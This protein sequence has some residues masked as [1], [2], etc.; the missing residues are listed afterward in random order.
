MPRF[1]PRRTCPRRA[2]RA[3]RRATPQRPARE[4]VGTG[5]GWRHR[6]RRRAG[7]TGR[8]T[9]TRAPRAGHGA[10][11][12]AP[13]PLASP[14]RLAG[15]RLPRASRDRA[16]RLLFERFAA[17]REPW[18]APRSWSA[19]CPWRGSSPR[20]TTAR[21]SPSTTSTRSPATALVKAVDRFDLGARP[22][23]HE[24]CGPDDRRGD[25]APLPRSHVGGARTARSPGALA[26]R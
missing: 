4:R 23:I 15:R 21:T 19:T 16:D 18:T 25:Q 3:P 1:S 12:L 14:V 9:S 2:R 8:T 26:A 17:T 10:R 6:S 22:S 5:P 20:R 11:C 13:P 7:G 24:L